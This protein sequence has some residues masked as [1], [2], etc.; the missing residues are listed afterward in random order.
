LGFDDTAGTV[1]KLEAE[2]PVANCHNFDDFDGVVKCVTGLLEQ[3]QSS[4]LSDLK[5]SHTHIRFWFRGQPDS[6]WQ[7]TPA[8]YRPDFH[9]KDEDARL[10]KERHLT[11]DFRAM[12]AGL[13]TSPKNESDTYFIQ[14]HY[15]MPTRLLDW[16]TSPL[17]ALHFAVESHLEKDAALFAMDAYELGPGQNG[18]REDGRDFLGIA[19]GQHPVFVKALHP[20]FQW[21]D[22]SHFPGFI[23]PV[24]PDHFDRRIALQRGCFTFHPPDRGTLTKNEVRTLKVF[25][26]PA[27]EKPRI[28]G[29]LAL[30]GVDQ[31]SIYGDLDHLAVYLKYVHNC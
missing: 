28:R 30:L 22:P 2:A 4:G 3:I 6:S 24:R 17:A 29:E 13:L 7:L 11:Q 21:R 16:T 23:L 27:A 18:K 12:S 26:I 14:Q 1:T 31:F 5:H 20:I 9:V 8:V 10:N 15:R 25:C 19:S